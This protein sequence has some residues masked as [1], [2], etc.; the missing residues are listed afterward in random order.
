MILKL[1]RKYSD[2]W[3]NKRTSNQMKGQP[4][5]VRDWLCNFCMYGVDSPYSVYL[6]G[7][8]WDI[9]ISI[10]WFWNIRTT[11]DD[12]ELILLVT[13]DKGFS[14]KVYFLSLPVEALY[15]CAGSC[16]GWTDPGLGR[17]SSLPWVNFTVV[18]LWRAPVGRIQDPNNTVLCIR[19]V[20][21]CVFKNSFDG[22]LHRM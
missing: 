6:I 5:S 18:Y 9:H 11:E 13:I 15:L 22:T 8:Y 4:V 10:H 3:M 7:L 19:S 2:A 21:L 14:I 16:S 20:C 12:T 17:V 1:W